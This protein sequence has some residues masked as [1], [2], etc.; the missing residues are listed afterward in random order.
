MIAV[1]L[2]ASTRVCAKLRPNW[3]FVAAPAVRRSEAG[4]GA[5]T[6]WLVLQV[7]ELVPP[8]EPD[9]V[10]PPLLL[11]CTKVVPNKLLFADCE[12]VSDRVE[13]RNRR[14]HSAVGAH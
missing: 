14:Q 4:V 7:I 11:R 9:G 10:Y 3:T 6:A 2:F 1:R 13:G 8:H 5:C 12:V